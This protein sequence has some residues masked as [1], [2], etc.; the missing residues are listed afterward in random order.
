VTISTGLTD[1]A[2]V[3]GP[4]PNTTPIAA[5]AETDL[6]IGNARRSTVLLGSAN[7]KYPSA[8]SLMVTG[9]EG[10]LLVDPSIDVAGR[11]GAPASI[12]RLLISH[13]HEDHLAGVSIFPTASIHAHHHD[14]EALRSIDAFM[15]VYGM[16]PAV[17]AVWQ[18]QVQSSFHYTER[19]D[20]QGFTDGDTFD[21]GGI[22]VTVV[23]LPGHTRGHCGFL[24]EPDGVF[25]V[26][27]VD[28]SSFG[29]YYGD[30]WSDLEDF[31][32]SMDRCAE[33]EAS[34]FVTSHHKGVIEGRT[35]FVSALTD[36]RSVITAREQR[37]LGFLAEPHTLEDMV[38]FRII[39]RPGTQILWADHVERVS[40]DMH[41]RRLVRTGAVVEAEPGYWRA[42]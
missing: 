25:F 11:G 35:N 30:H 31:E 1:S 5:L 42:A 32:R 40:I 10:A 20:A 24:V 33:V 29:P 17:R 6:V 34:W 38:E 14:A 9:T 27:D 18:E 23:H 8:N 22:T 4:T 13:A 7:G 39:Y 37:L 15:D 36:F 3:T 12:D 2:S 26:A 16:P 41:L 28:L 21:L 19:K